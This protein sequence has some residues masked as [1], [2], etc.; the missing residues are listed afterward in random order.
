MAAL[1]LLAPGA[2]RAEPQAAPIPPEAAVKPEAVHGL[3]VAY[4]NFGRIRGP[5]SSGID[6]LEIAKS[7]VAQYPPDVT[8]ELAAAHIDFPAGPTTVVW[9]DRTTLAEYLLADPAARENP[10]AQLAY[11]MSSRNI[12]VFTGFIKVDKAGTYTF[13]I[14]NDDSDEL[15]IGGVVVHTV[16]AGGFM[17]RTW[18]PYLARAEFVEPGIYPVRIL[19]YDMA[20]HIGIEVYSDLEPHGP[21]VDAGGGQTL[22]L[23]TFL[24]EKP[25]EK[26]AETPAKQPSQH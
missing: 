16:P 1:V 24:T 13:R 15:T 9:A 11:Q 5:G 25:A 10:P 2:G 23:L 26:P 20:Q 4:H 3:K 12:F 17:H 18:E 19:H 14:P 7:F 22:F 21:A 8:C 6:S